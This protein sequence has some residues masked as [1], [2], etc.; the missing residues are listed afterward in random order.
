[1]FVGQ[2]AANATRPFSFCGWSTPV[3]SFPCRGALQRRPLLDCRRR[4]FLALRYRARAL[5]LSAKVVIPSAARDLL[6]LFS[7]CPVYSGLCALCV[8]SLSSLLTFNF[9]LSTSFF[10]IPTLDPNH[11]KQKTQRRT[12]LETPGRRSRPAPA[13]LRRIHA[14]SGAPSPR[15]RRSPPDRTQQS[16]SRDRGAL[17]P[18]DS[19]GLP[20]RPSAVAPRHQPRGDRF[21]AEHSPPPSHPCAR[22]RPMLLLS[23]PD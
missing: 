5:A 2:V 14:S 9:Q 13:P 23:A 19:R 3:R 7:L 11:E 10:D 6:F 15:P 12:T 8:K 18:G 17:A 4:F 21:P 16:R 22:A 20:N 1:M